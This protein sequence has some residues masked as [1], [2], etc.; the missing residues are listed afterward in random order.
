MFSPQ[1]TIHVTVDNQYLLF[2]KYT[3]L[4][5]QSLLVHYQQ[6]NESPQYIDWQ[7]DSK[8]EDLSTKEYCH[9]SDVAYHSDM[10]KCLRYLFA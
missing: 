6:T 7:I 3:T 5:F 9:L 4:K 10:T 8:L 1:S 2:T